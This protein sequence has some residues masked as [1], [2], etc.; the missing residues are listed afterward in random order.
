M[1]VA[2]KIWRKLLYIISP[3]YN[4]RDKNIDVELIKSLSKLNKNRIVKLE[5]PVDKCVTGVYWSLDENNPFISTLNENNMMVLKQYYE[6]FKPDNINELLNIF[7][8]NDYGML[9]PYALI[10]PWENNKSTQEVI[11]GRNLQS[12][13][14][15]SKYGYSNLTIFEGGHTDYGPVNN[16][17]LSIELKR[18][19]GLNESINKKGYFE[20][21]RLSPNAITGIFFLNK[22]RE[23][24]FYISGGKHRSYVLAHQGYNK[25]PV[26]INTNAPV[27]NESDIN[28]WPQVANNRYTEEEAAQVFNNFFRLS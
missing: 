25:I 27:V 26:I 28:Q 24:R 21:L 7:I 16:D 10:F 9:P 3:I 8:K 1:M 6:N 19:F 15:N 14:E 2:K 22:K 13:K 5:I 18:I 20:K 12:I 23:W 4:Y 11:K 17:K